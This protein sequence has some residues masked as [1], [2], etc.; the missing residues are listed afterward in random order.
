SHNYME[1]TSGFLW[2]NQIPG[3]Q[4]K[5]HRPALGSVVSRLRG[6]G[7]VPPFVSLWGTE[8]PEAEDP[9]FLGPAHRPFLPPGP[10]IDNLGLHKGTPLER[11]GERKELLRTF[12]SLRRDVDARGEMAGMDVFTGRALEMLTSSR[13]RGAFDIDREP[14]QV[15]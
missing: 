2:G 10:G 7:K 15:R 12:D 14:I 11:V 13:A 9:P 1:I 6:S 5:S 8:P 4:G 3:G